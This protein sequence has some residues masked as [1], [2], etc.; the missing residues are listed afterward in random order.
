MK[1]KEMYYKDPRVRDLTWEIDDLCWDSFLARLFDPDETKLQLIS[2]QRSAKIAELKSLLQSNASDL[3]LLLEIFALN[4][5][6]IRA[7]I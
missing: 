3:D 4:R 7:N 6:I 1:L 2:D 5:E